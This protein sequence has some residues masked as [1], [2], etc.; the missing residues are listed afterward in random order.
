MV[1]PDPKAAEDVIHQGMDKSKIIDK[2]RREAWENST[3]WHP[4]A[5]VW[6]L[7][8]KPLSE[9]DPPTV[10]EQCMADCKEREKNR[11]RECAEIRKRVQAKLKDLGC[12]SSVKSTDKTTTCGIG[13]KRGA[14]SAP[15]PTPAKKG[16]KGKKRQKTA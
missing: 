8:L 11:K 1:W 3:Q 4:L 9:P 7:E 16:K 5:D 13:K 15:A 2:D 12:P 6:S 10:S 14:K